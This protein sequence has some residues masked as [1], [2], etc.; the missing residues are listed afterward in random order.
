MEQRGRVFSFFFL[1]TKEQI[2]GGKIKKRIALF[3]RRKC[4]HGRRNEGRIPSEASRLRKEKRRSDQDGRG[5]LLHTREGEK[6]GPLEAFQKTLRSIFH[7]VI[8][9]LFRRLRL[10]KVCQRSRAARQRGVN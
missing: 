3:E 9:R 6:L 8:V 1:T 4:K 2:T 7:H 10:T 5:V